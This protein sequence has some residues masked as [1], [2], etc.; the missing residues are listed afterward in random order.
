MRMSNFRFV[1]A[2]AAAPSVASAQTIDR[3]EVGAM[4]E[5]V[6]EAR[7]RQHLAPLAGDARL[8][9][10][11]EAHSL[12]MARANFFSHTSPN[13]GSPS[14][15]ATRAGITY[16]LVAENIA[17]NRSARAA[18][19]SL[20]ASDG[21]RAN[22]LH[23][24]LRSVGIGIV[25]SDRGYYVTQ[26]FATFGDEAPRPAP[27]AV[28][29]AVPA[30]AARPAAPAAPAATARRDRAPVDR[31]NDRDDTTAGQPSSDWGFPQWAQIPQIFGLPVIP[32]LTAPSAPEGPRQNGRN[33]DRAPA[34]RRPDAARRSQAPRRWVIQTPFGPF[35]VQAADPNGAPEGDVSERAEESDDSDNG[36]VDLDEE[37]TRP[38]APA[39]RTP[40]R[41]PSRRTVPHFQAPQ[42]PP[43]TTPHRVTAVELP[44][45]V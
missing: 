12:D 40:S 28:P 44:P 9:G 36:A 19:D 4:R 1:T 34:Q 18:F 39:A 23:V 20:M 14:D 32:G 3:G 8:D 15:R 21:H 22:I 11:A 42:P 38:R 27:A 16:R 41:A 35:V 10:V 13:T 31:D 7:A 33:A 30:P 43:R 6:N 45:V 5:W 17:M 25:Q 2:V 29:T 24:G 26:V 37:R